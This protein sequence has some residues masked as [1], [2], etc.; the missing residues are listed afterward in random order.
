MDVHMFK[1]RTFRKTVL[2]YAIIIII[3]ILIFSYISIQNIIDENH[4]KAITMHNAD[5]QRVS[6]ALD[7]K[8]MEL[9]HIGNR[10]HH[11]KWVTRLAMNMNYSDR[12]F[13]LMK[14]QEISQELNNDIVFTGILSNIAVVFP[15]KDLVI[16]PDGWYEVD[17]YFLDIAKI[18][19]EDTENIYSNIVN[20]GYFEVVGDIDKSARS[21]SKGELVIFQSLEISKKPRA[22]VLFFIDRQS[23]QSY[24]N[25]ITLPNLGSFTI[26]NGDINVHHED[27]SQYFKESEGE[28]LTFSMLSGITPWE[29]T[30][31][32]SNS[33]PSINAEQLFSLYIG[34]TLSLL[35]GFIMALILAVISYKPLY[36]LLNK[37]FK[38]DDVYVETTREPFGEYN[39]IE[40]SFTNL[41]DQNE[42]MMN[43]MKDYENTVKNNLLLRLLKG[44]F[45]DSKLKGK[46]KEIGISYSNVDYFCVILINI[47]YAEVDIPEDMFMRKQSVISSLIIAEQIVEDYNV[48]YEIVDV[49]DDT[50]ALIMN[51][52][53]GDKNIEFLE[54]LFLK[55]KTS[56]E[57]SSDIEISMTMGNI[58]KGIIGI[59]KSYQ[60]AR[61]NLDYVIF[62]EDEFTD[63]INSELYYYPTD[64]EI[65]L[66]NNLKI[67]D[68]D[69]VNRIID[70]MKLE[71]ENRN[72]PKE[73]IIRLISV[74]METQMRVLDELNIDAQLYHK[75]FEKV[76]TLGD[77]EKMWAYIYDASDR[78]CYRNRYANTTSNFEL[79]NDIVKYIDENYYDP[80]LS[81][82][83]LGEVFDMSVSSL[84]KLFKAVTGINYSEY[85]CRTRMEQAK[86]LL[87]DTE[88]SIGLIANEVGYE[89]EYSFRRA[90]RRYEG[91]TPNEYMQTNA[92]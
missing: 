75:D 54:E 10:L 59:S 33:S 81:L 36:N 6:T 13:N 55:V 68:V 71:N 16:S 51:F 82:T 18:R 84:S 8:L 77:I 61:H 28:L 66:I 92:Q 88:K 50:F 35:A 9:M 23:L 46:L 7:A 57:K 2:Y 43:R 52:G 40:N 79:A 56:I 67:G 91:I 72:L 25:R 42:E 19:Q 47:S 65:Q 70:E 73:S 11:S 80:N 83:K 5:T 12:E 49:L 30:C 1:S 14:R 86:L 63:V 17:D 78:I 76:I 48:D 37:I 22:V 85:L 39:A 21:G 3:P 24:I 29:Y 26:T 38:Y 20:Y 69:T 27:F 53:Q 90:F 58:E 64:W 34:I 32:Y 44:Y 89:N 62:G 45:D 4:N 31:T 60:M 74:I 41:V 87:K 15:H